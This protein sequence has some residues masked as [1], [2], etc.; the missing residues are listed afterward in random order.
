[1]EFFH[2]EDVF[3]QALRLIKKT[4]PLTQGPPLKA[5]GAGEASGKA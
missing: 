1:M 3:Y 5:I 2:D 4:A